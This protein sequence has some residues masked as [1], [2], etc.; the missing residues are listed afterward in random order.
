M[1]LTPSTDLTALI[2]VPVLVGGVRTGVIDFARHGAE[3]REPALAGGVAVTWR[4]NLPDGRVSNS[5][6]FINYGTPV[7]PLSQQ[8]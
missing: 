1:L 5:G 7:E 8:P 2:G 3:C 6:F 4:E